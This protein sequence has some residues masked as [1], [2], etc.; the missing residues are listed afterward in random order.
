MAE[1]DVLR[2]QQF[3]LARHLR[4]PAA[5]AAPP[6]IEARRLEVYRDLFYNGIQSLL[7]GNFPVIRK[8]LDEAAWHAL[9][10]RF[11]ADHRCATPLFT[12]VGHEF[13][14]YL[15]RRQ[16]E[17][18]GDPPWLAELAH[19]EWVELALQISDAQAPP[20][21]APT[22]A[23]PAAQPDTLIDRALRVSP[24]AW[25]LAYRWP[26]HRIG[27]DFRPDTAPVAPTLLLV[28]RDADG[29]V[30]FS[31]LSP[32]VFRLLQLL[33]DGSGRSG[34]QALAQLAGEAGADDIDAFVAD[35]RAML[36]RL[37]DE[38]TVWVP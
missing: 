22:A 21:R 15:Q 1:A 36:E 26:V 16:D 7:A 3:A 14:Q 27:P 12:R 20:V 13:V 5:N 9:V 24:L 38:G 17:R 10:R 18:A 37:H 11:Y 23:G 19:Y 32:L 31:E 30:R 2:E 34:R 25:P 4:D 35:G 29:E 28:R 6:G 33:G 8:T